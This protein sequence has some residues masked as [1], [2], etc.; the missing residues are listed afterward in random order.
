MGCRLFNLAHA[1]LHVRATGKRSLPVAHEVKMN[2]TLLVLIYVTI[3]LA[4]S[5][6]AAESGPVSAHQSPARP[7]VVFIIADQWRAQAFGFAGD[8]N[9]NS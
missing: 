2:R 1:T 5:A 9:A 3:A 7:N 6:A 4:T 8:P